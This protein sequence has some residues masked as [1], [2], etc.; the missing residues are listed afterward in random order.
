[1]ITSRGGRYL[2]APV[3]GNRQ[4]SENGMLV[5]LAAGDKALFDDCSSC[6]QAMGKKSF[7]LG[8]SVLIESSNISPLKKY[9][10]ELLIRIF[11]FILV[12]GQGY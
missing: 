3:S 1:M 11:S 2:E 9:S 8:R 7:Y 12:K 5:I 6:F 4:L 10:F